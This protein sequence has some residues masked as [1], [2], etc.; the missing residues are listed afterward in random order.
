MTTT[1]TL[2]W[3]QGFARGKVT[4]AKFRSA[5][6]PEV[7]S[8]N[9][10][11][12]VLQ[13]FSD[14]MVRHARGE[15]IPSSAVKSLHRRALSKRF[16]DWDGLIIA[17]IST[18]ATTFRNKP[19]RAWLPALLAAAGRFDEVVD[20]EPEFVTNGPQRKDWLV[21]VTALAGSGREDLARSLVE[22][23]DEH[24]PEDGSNLTVWGDDALSKEFARLREQA[25][26]G[27]VL[28][29]FFHLPFCGGTSMIVSLKSII[30]WGR[31]VQINR[32][33]GLLQMEHA[34][35]LS[36]EDTARLMLVHQHHPFAFQLP[37]RELSHFTVL[38]DPVSQIRSGYFKRLS[39]PGILPTRDESPTFDQHIDYT[40][41][42][43][44]TNMLA[45]QIVTTH[46]DL[47]STYRKRF[48][49]S[50]TFESVRA[51]EDMFWLE[52]TAAL[53]ENDLLRMCR[54]TLDERF[55]L[56]GTMRHLE[57][58]HI[59]ATAS[60]GSYTADR[61]GH[62]GRSGQPERTDDES[63]AVRRLRDANGVDQILYDE[64]TARFERDHAS[65]I[66]LVASH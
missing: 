36:T 63:D 65:L 14:L 45:R 13:E 12:D 62:R 38:R 10:R 5:F 61:V 11:D 18:L 3:R 34:L 15:E 20:I 58:S 16:S 2:D 44:M 54:E 57:A 49:G 17:V 53:S 9:R 52:A 47:S 6:G 19:A 26:S 21:V 23:L 46:P 59:A 7:T 43:R 55:H 56:V 51:E 31:M 48:S 40:I 66:D 8:R 41:K 24:F 1:R 35:Q 39:T 25:P 64:Y 32:R 28:P 37:G 30:P 42:Q 60:T 29:V 33:Y 27:T 22:R 50:G 4:G